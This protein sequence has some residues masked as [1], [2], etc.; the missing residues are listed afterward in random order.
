M[1]QGQKEHSIMLFKRADDLLQP[2]LA[3]KCLNGHASYEQ[4]NLGL[5]QLQLGFQKWPA[6]SQFL[7]RRTSIPIT[8]RVTSGIT[9]CER[10]QIGVLVQIA[11]RESRLL[12]P[13]LQNTTTRPTKRA[14]F[15]H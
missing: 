3:K 14:S 8:T 10:T 5:Q 4:H 7:R 13:L 11:G 6:E 2:P 9:A 12:K 1:W 15:R